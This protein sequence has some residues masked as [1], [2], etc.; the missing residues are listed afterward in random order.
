MA[1]ACAVFF[2]SSDG[3]HQHF[4]SFPTRRSSD[5]ADPLAR[6]GCAAA[7]FQPRFRQG[8]AAAAGIRSEEHTSEL[9]SPDHL[10]CS[11]LLEK[12]NRAP[13]ANRAERRRRAAPAAAGCSRGGGAAKG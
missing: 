7:R 5:L 10:V 3:Q 11:L 12:K 4:H 1:L 9:Q 6:G 8:P 2:F 13:A